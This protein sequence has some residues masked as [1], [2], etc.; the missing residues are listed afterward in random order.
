MCFPAKEDAG[1]SD[2]T[3]TDSLESE[4]MLSA[5]IFSC[6]PAL[7]ID[8]EDSNLN[9]TVEETNLEEQMEAEALRN[10]GGFISHKFPQYSFLGSNI[11]PED[12][13]WIGE[14]C[15]TAG[16]LKTPSGDFFVFG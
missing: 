12:N 11:T 8:D 9:F 6:D 15:R 2:N 14:I 10:I 16:K 7:T 4:L 13:T 5:M 3:G 1:Q